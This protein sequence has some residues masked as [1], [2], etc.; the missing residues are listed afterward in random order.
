MVARTTRRA[1][2]PRRA[3][4]CRP[5]R[6][7]VLPGGQDPARRGPALSRRWWCCSAPPA[8]L[9]K[10]KLLPGLYHLAT[11]GFIPQCRVIGVSL[12]DIDADGLPPDRPRRARRV[13]RPQDHRRRLGDLCADPGLRAAGRRRAGAGA[14]P[15]R[16]RSQPGHRMPAPALPERAAQRRAAGGAPARRGGAGRA[17]AHRDGEALRHRP[18]QRGAR[19]TARCTRCSRGADL[20][21]RPLPGQG[22]GAE[23]PGLPV[24][25]RPVRA[26]LEPQLHR[27][28]ADRRARDLG[29]GS[30]AASTS[31]PAPTATWW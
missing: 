14:P 26:D 9:A 23:H 25:Q 8:D 12:D 21:H 10:R 11:A 29:L 27:P 30:A 17:L 3:R 22:A 16:R 24:R 4:R 19:S 18:G 6:G 13:L 7:A 5:G 28:R 15:W 31:R 2:G 20:P 1:V